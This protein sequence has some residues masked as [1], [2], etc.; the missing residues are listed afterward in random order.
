[1]REHKDK[2]QV[3]NEA[4]RLVLDCVGGSQAKASDF[5]FVLRV[6]QLANTASLRKFSLPPLVFLIHPLPPILHHYSFQ[7]QNYDVKVK[8]IIRLSVLCYFLYPKLKY[9][10]I[11][12]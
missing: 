1:M 2:V 4:G 12:I 11:F 7:L 9:V 5:F 8:R 3:T 6:P 10:A